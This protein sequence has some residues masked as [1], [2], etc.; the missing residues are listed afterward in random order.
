MAN[1]QEVVAMRRALSLATSADAPTG[2]NPR[3]GA[4]ILDRS[5]TVVGEGYHRG[6]GS[7]HAE[8]MALEQA[9]ERAAGGV[10]VVTLEPCHHSGRT[11]PC[12]DALLKAEIAR[13][14]FAQPDSNPIAA[15]G[16]AFLQA[17]GVGTEG[18]VLVD[19]AMALNPMWT[20]AMAQQ[21]PFVTWKFAASLDGRVAA[22]DG[23]SRWI[24]SEAARAD[25][26]RLRATVG[27]IVVGTGTVLQDD[28][29]LTVRDARFAGVAPM[30][31]VVGERQLPKSA[32]VLDDAAPTLL[33]HSHDPVVVLKQL[34][35]LDVQH[36]LLEGGP[37]LAAAFVRAGVVDRV[38]A[39]VA[40]MLL[41]G[42]RNAL[43]DPAMRSIA[44]ALRLQPESIERIG[45]DVRITAT[46]P[47]L[48]TLSVGRS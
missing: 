37:I 17:A 18:A 13:V 19:E 33:I 40:P 35:M 41:G 32:R 22:A 26:H 2:P 25:V 23:S 5:G 11:G 28:P 21:R 42:G 24:S 7:P 6:A 12:T 44:Q 15:G 27:A 48:S 34:F 3:V 29:Q 47:S 10:A 8:V 38:V 30:R 9:G 4:V 46:L 1:T 39:Y 16:A 43:D 36:V 31:V 14:V 20:F 45:D